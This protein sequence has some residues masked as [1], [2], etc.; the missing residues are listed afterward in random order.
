MSELRA[1]QERIAQ[2][3]EEIHQHNHRYY[4]LDQPQITDAQYD[5]LM[6][7]LS[8]LEQAHP[9]LVMA[10]SPTQRVGGKPLAGFS[11]VRHRVP[12]LSLS[13][14]FGAEDL[15]EFDRKVRAGLGEAA[16]EYVVELK[17]DGLAIGLTY[18]QGGFVQ[19]AT[20]GDGEVS[21]K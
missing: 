2:L 20:R 16:V 21:L 5:L 6:R 10:D 11:T 4:V 13:N 14:A 3:R 18:E 8:S 17:I 7:E 15:R 1:V 9:E 19:G 12:M